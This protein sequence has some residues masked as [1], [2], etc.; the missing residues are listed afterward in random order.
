MSQL[1]HAI[2]SMLEEEGSHEV[3][4]RST[5]FAIRSIQAD[6]EGEGRCQV[7][8]FEPSPDRIIAF[9]YKSSRLAFSRDR[10][11]Y[12]HVQLRGATLPDVESALREVLN[13]QRGGFR[14]SERPASI[15]RAMTF[16]IPDEIDTGDDS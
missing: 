16:E 14:P 9:C 7:W 8:F 2:Q 11:S 13:W 4:P 6:A 1:I 12:G 10:F 5:G 15:K 3:L